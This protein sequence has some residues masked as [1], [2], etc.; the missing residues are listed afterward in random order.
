MQPP[1]DPFESSSSKFLEALGITDDD[2]YF[3]RLR[4]GT[5][6]VTYLTIQQGPVK[7]SNE[8]NEASAEVD[9]LIMARPF[10][11]L[12]MQSMRPDLDFMLSI[13]PWVHPS[14]TYDIMFKLNMD[15]V[16]TMAT[17]SPQLKGQYLREL[18]NLDGTP[19]TETGGPDDDSSDDIIGGGED[20]GNDD[21]MALP[22]QKNDTGISGA[23]ANLKDYHISTEDKKRINPVHYILPSQRRLI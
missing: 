15:E 3:I 10:R 4:S 11:I 7:E 21:V 5:D 19:P 22:D 2:I 6:L 20:S 14:L 17:A 13:I 8:S 16:Q 23:Y 9:G 18:A 1:K 12:Y